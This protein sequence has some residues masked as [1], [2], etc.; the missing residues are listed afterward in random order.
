MI[1]NYFYKKYHNEKK[2]FWMVDKI[3]EEMKY[4][5]GYAGSTKNLWVWAKADE[6]FET[7]YILNSSTFYDNTRVVENIMKGIPIIVKVDGKPLGGLSHYVVA[8]GDGKI[9]DPWDG[10]IKPF[11]SYKPLGYHVYTYKKKASSNP[12][13]TTSDTEKHEDPLDKEIITNSNNWNYLRKKYDISDVKQIDDKI[14]QY[15]KK[16]V[17]ILATGAK[18]QAEYEAKI[19]KLKNELYACGELNKKLEK[20]VEKLQDKPVK[21]DEDSNQQSENKVPIIIKEKGLLFTKKFPWIKFFDQI[22]VEKK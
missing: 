18:L 3:N 12:S 20:E 2:D 14:E 16:I 13:N 22:T 4:K 1:L 17:K 10:K 11:S 15:E 21:S 5:G 9:V 19:L 7:E 8:I 6:I